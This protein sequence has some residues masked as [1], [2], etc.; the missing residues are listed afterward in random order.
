[1]FL[2]RVLGNIQ[3]SFAVQIQKPE[4][5]QTRL[6]SKR[7]VILDKYIRGEEMELKKPGPLSI[8][9][10]IRQSQPLEPLKYKLQDLPLGHDPLIPLGNIEHLP[11]FIE[12]TS[13]H[14]LPVYTQYKQMRHLK[15]TE[16]RKISGDIS[17]LVTELQKVTNRSE[18]RVKV[19]SIVIHGLHV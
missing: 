9:R 11:F 2:K 15:Y 16:I 4:L 3:R 12:R 17:E 19:G 7:K 14:N 8:K 10:I 18:I 1:M 5:Y 13:S 6:D